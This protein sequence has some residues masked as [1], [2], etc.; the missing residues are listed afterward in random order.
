MAKKLEWNWYIYFV[1]IKSLTRCCIVKILQL[2]RS[3]L[4]IHLKWHCALPSGTQLLPAVTFR[5]WPVTVNTGW[6]HECNHRA[7]K[8]I[9]SLWNYHLYIPRWHSKATNSM[10]TGRV[11]GWEAAKATWPSKLQA[12]PLVT[13]ASTAGDSFSVFVPQFSSQNG[14]ESLFHPLNC[15]D[16]R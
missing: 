10:K 6:Q 14:N 9:S 1:K 4:N 2:K 12:W 3:P 8:C 11:G 7:R 16:Y 15:R 5:T 13:R